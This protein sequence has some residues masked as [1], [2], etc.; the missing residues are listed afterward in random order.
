MKWNETTL[1]RFSFC[2]NEW[3]GMWVRGA[4]HLEKIQ[5]NGKLFKKKWEKE[6]DVRIIWKQCQ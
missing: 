6:R 5:K 2:W 3:N 1:V 4:G